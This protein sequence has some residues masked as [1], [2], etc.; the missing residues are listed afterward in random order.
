MLNSLCC[1]T[2]GLWPLRRREEHNMSGQQRYDRPVAAHC[3]ARVHPT[4]WEIPTWK[5]QAT[6]E[7][8][9]GTIWSGAVLRCR[10]SHPS[11]RGPRIVEPIP[12]QRSAPSVKHRPPRR[13]RP[14][15]NRKRLISKR[16]WE[17][18]VSVRQSWGHRRGGARYAKGTIRVE[19][20]AVATGRA[21]WEPDRTV[22]A[23]TKM[24]ATAMARRA[25]RAE[26]ELP[27]S[28]ESA[29]LTA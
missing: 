17:Q 12:R 2:R 7:A 18:L 28:K 23:R 27:S 11:R 3:T 25:V 22:A 1:S 20:P 6:P 9:A 21:I 19:T 8:I 14:R 29:R 15:S 16:R 26:A 5:A 24:T 13:K 4:S 10:G